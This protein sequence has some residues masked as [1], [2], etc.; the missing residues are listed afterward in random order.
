MDEQTQGAFDERIQWINQVTDLAR[1][2]RLDRVW[3]AIQD[4][5]DEHLRSLILVLV[6]TRVDDYERVKDHYRDWM[7]E[8]MK[9]WPMASDN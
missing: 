5:D 4:V 3:A 9:E 8:R 2:G 1:D 6:L 7:R